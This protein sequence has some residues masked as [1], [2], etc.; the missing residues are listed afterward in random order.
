MSKEAR[1][2]VMYHK[3]FAAEDENVPIQINF[4]VQYSIENCIAKKQDKHLQ[5]TIQL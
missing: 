1:A 3:S 2:K 4:L 5:P